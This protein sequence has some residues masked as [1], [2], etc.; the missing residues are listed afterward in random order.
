MPWLLQ[1]FPSH[2]AY[3]TAD[4]DEI[5]GD[6]KP[7]M[8]HV[9]VNSFDSMVFLKR[10]DRFESRPLPIEAQFAPV[11]AICAADF[12][13][14]GNQDLFL[15]QNFF[16]PDPDTSAY[17]GGQGLLL[18]GDG[19]G[20]F[21]ALSAAESG[22]AIYGE[23]RGA[24]VCDYDHDGRIDLAVA[25][26][27]AATKLFRNVGAPPGLRVILAGRPENPKAIGAVLR[28]STTD[29]KLGPAR[30]LK[31]GAGYWSQDGTTQVVPAD[32]T[33][34]EVRWPDGAKTTSDVPAGVKAITIAADGK[35][36]ASNQ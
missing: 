7:K 11:F 17:D 21:R 33:R 23:G 3:S 16:G 4:V 14:D 12:D 20:N 35:V 5:L 18:K 32:T 31:A 13:G 24:A 2:A 34:I 26:N 25:Q 27:G 9:T 8:K 30:E 6:A 19:R 28:T 10:G 15:A 1:R 36:T 29:N 22:I